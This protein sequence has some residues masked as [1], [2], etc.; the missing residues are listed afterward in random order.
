MLIVS[1]LVG[2][3]T[4]VNSIFHKIVQTLHNVSISKV[5]IATIIISEA[6]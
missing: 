6:I 1:V 5:K 3:K 4:K 2:I